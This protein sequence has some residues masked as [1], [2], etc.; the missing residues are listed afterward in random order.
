MFAQVFP[1]FQ[2]EGRFAVLP[3]LYAEGVMN[4]AVRPTAAAPTMQG[5]IAVITLFV[6]VFVLGIIIKRSIEQK[7][8]PYKQEIFRDQKDF[9]LAMARAEK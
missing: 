5:V 3:T 2:D 8:N 7:R 9:Q 6:N 4:P 1:L